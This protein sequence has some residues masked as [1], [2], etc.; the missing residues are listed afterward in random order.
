MKRAPS[1]PWSRG[2]IPDRE[3]PHRPLEAP[4]IRSLHEGDR[5]RVATRDEGRDAHRVEGRLGEDHVA[6]GVCPWPGGS[7]ISTPVFRPVRLAPSCCV[8]LGTSS[9]AATWAATCT[10][11]RSIICRTAPLAR[12]AM[13]SAS[14]WH[15]FGCPEELVGERQSDGLDPREVK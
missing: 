1:L 5:D 3:D 7:G 11:A 14:G 15:D 4:V 6:A 8:K 12:I 9:D 10:S 13:M 2:F